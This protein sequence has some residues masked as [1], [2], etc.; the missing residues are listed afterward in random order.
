MFPKLIS[1]VYVINLISS[2]ERK[3]HIHKEFKKNKIDDYEI[4]EAT[5]K[6]SDEVRTIM[7][8]DLISKTPHVLIK[9]QVGNW[10]S[11][12]NVMKDI[13][14]KDHRDLIM[15]CED[16]IVFTDK[17]MNI[18]QEMI[19]L[20]NLENNKINLKNPILIRLG[21]GLSPNH[22]LKHA[23]V[24]EKK[25]IMSNP[26]FLCNKMFAESFLKN[27]KIINVTSDI[28]IH[29]AILSK[30]KTIQAFTIL[31]QPIT[32]LSWGKNKKF[33]STIH[34]KGIDE[35]D[36]KLMKTHIK[37]L[38]YKDFLCIGHPCCEMKSISFYLQQMGYNVGLDNMKKNGICSWM[39]AVEDEKYPLGKVN[40][41][42]RY[43]FQNII[44]IVRNPFDA[45]PSIILQNKNS[46]NNTS[47]NFKKKHIK[48]QLGIDLP[49]SNNT[50]SIYE[51][52]LAI[53]TF[54]YWN[55][56]CENLKPDLICQ[57]ENISS[58]QKFNKNKDI[59]HKTY[60]DR[61]ENINKKYYNK[62]DISIDL[63]KKID[64]S[65]KVELQ[66]FCK[67]YNYNY[68]LNSENII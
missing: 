3:E 17:G 40:N 14:E 32:E 15:I 28:Y 63:Y 6:D 30:D 2:I 29:R 11:F 61:E 25:I 42:S 13:I 5:D 9:Q 37:K 39:L 48:Q 23:P 16:D 57:I 67:K 36:K 66:D 60:N 65:L 59:N 27:L 49:H 12:I 41:K 22:T 8:T 4:F 26:A 43:F 62:S 58:L 10:C 20:K 50:E 21:S 55:K 34:P 1:K 19:T 51:I 46:S 24:F 35:K 31:P 7:K 68:L 64:E 45:I 52:E 47:Y 56:I 38:E 53:K 33:A 18:I 44:H 54:I